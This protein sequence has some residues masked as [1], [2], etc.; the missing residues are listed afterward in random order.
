MVPHTEDIARFVLRIGAFRIEEV[1]RD[2]KDLR[3]GM[4][5]SGTPIG[6]PER[7]DRRA[8]TAARAG[9]PH[10]ARNVAPGGPGGMARDQ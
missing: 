1:F 7:R 8:L 5:L 9:D 2:R 4:G 10:A 3:F 6:T